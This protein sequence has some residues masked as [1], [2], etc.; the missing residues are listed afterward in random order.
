MFHLSLDVCFPAQERKR[1]LLATGYI[2]SALVGSCEIDCAQ[3]HKIVVVGDQIVGTLSVSK[4]S[5][6]QFKKDMMK[7]HAVIKQL[8]SLLNRY[9]V[10]KGINEAQKIE[11]VKTVGDES[12]TLFRYSINAKKEYQKE[13]KAVLHSIC[14]EKEVTFSI[15][16]L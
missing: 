7:S 15:R 16:I 12:H 4:C 11:L 3:G 14:E 8:N 5:S 6:R 1:P 2:C 13:I 10:K 9:L